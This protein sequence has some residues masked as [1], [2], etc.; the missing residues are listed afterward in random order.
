M[1]LV[2][3]LAREKSNDEQL[4]DAVRVSHIYT[5]TY[6]IPDHS[7]TVLVVLDSKLELILP[8]IHLM[9]LICQPRP[10]LTY[11]LNIESR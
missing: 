1:K 7:S 3:E 9:K 8:A 11:L 5:G 2:N 6:A 10:F 4:L